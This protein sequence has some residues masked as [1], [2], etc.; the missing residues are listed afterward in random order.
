MKLAA[1]TMATPE[2]TL[3]EAIELF[4]DL[5]LDGIE[6]T[7]QEDYKCGLYITASARERKE[8]LDACQA[9]NLEVC[10]V[11]PY[12]W[13]LNSPDEAMRRSQIDGFKGSIVL[14]SDLNCKVVRGLAGG[15]VSPQNRAQSLDLL[16]T[17]LQELG[18]FAGERGV[19]IAIENHRVTMAITAAQTMEVIDA[20]GLD[21]VGV[22]YDQA[23]V[24]QWQGEDYEEA[25]DLQ[26]ERL[27][28][29]HLK[30]IKFVEGKEKEGKR[31]ATLPGE[32]IIPCRE[33]VAALQSR[34]YEGYVSF[35]YERRFHP[36][37][38]PEARVGIKA[39]IDL[40]RS[41]L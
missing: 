17:S 18:E 22:L 34:G 37:E 16:V 36:D 2:L 15:E 30:D 3:I 4:A 21:S 19:R 7:Y 31:Y 32:G 20:V 26:W 27:V 5:G 23:N 29:V 35:E 12:F 9:R 10:C 14:A 40:V 25:L 6:I 33:I 39:C 11:T 41:V 38:L 8:I 13:E 28:H 1:H 24:T